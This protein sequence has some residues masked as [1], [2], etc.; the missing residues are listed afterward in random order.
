MYRDICPSIEFEQ[1]YREGFVN[2]KSDGVQGVKIMSMLISEYGYY[3]LGYSD[4][5]EISTRPTNTS[6]DYYNQ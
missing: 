3:G 4:G 1:G 2:G 5:L 6:K